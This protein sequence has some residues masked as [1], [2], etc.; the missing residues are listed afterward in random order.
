MFR[1]IKLVLA[2]IETVEQLKEI[3][4][5]VIE[6]IDDRLPMI[7][8]IEENKRLKER[9]EELEL[10]LEEAKTAPNGTSINSVN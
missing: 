1:E 4:D 5:S 3:K 10:E 6:Y 9:I 2:K 8:I 7:T